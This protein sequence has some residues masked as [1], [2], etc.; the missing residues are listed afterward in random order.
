MGDVLR[1]PERLHK[2]VKSLCC[3]CNVVSLFRD[4]IAEAEPR[5]ARGN[6]VKSRHVLVAPRWC[7]DWIAQRFDHVGDWSWV[8]CC[9]AGHLGPLDAAH[10][11][12]EDASVPST[13]K[14]VLAIL[15]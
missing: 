7:R 15:L 14:R 3:R 12:F 6:D 2:R 8:S 4:L 9:F 11:H 5:N 1:V 10:T 13:S